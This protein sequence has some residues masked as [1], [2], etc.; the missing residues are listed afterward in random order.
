[1]PAEL[2]AVGSC[3][4]AAKN[5]HSEGFWQNTFLVSV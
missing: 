5:V 2:E 1:M 3:R 4:A